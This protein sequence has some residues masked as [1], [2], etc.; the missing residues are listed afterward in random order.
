MRGLF[1]FFLDLTVIYTTIK[2][3]VIV[4]AH[5]LIPSLSR[6]SIR[7][8]GGG[9]KSAPFIFTNMAIRDETFMNNFNLSLPFF[10]V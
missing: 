8:G 2:S 1:V 7:G 10:V 5:F 9:E 3:L 4:D 6:G